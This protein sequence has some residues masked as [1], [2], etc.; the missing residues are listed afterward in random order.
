MGEQIG[1]S[2]KEIYLFVAD[3]YTKGT[4]PSN[5]FTSA[6]REK[7]ISSSYNNNLKSQSLIHVKR[8]KNTYCPEENT[9]PFILYSVLDRSHHDHMLS[10]TVQARTV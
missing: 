6:G 5:L 3:R 1:K 2:D 9:A 4:R 7:L 10:H 8:N